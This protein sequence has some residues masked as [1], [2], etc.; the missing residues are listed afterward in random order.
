MCSHSVVKLHEASE[1]FVM[2]AYVREMTVKK[3]CKCGEYG[4]FEHKFVLLA[5]L[6]EKYMDLFNELRLFIWPAICPSA[7]T[8]TFDITRKLF[9]KF[10][11]NSHAYSHY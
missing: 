7:K 8:L 1:M 5:H 6:F 2:V 4:S 10:C 9:T 11:H 3:S